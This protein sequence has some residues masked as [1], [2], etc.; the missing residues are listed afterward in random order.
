V[1]DWLERGLSVALTVCAVVI[2]TVLIHQ[3]FGS[4]APVEQQKESPAPPVRIDNWQE[5]LDAGLV[6]GDSNGGLHLVVFGDLECPYCRAFHMRIRALEQKYPG[7]ITLSY[8]H[9]PL[10]RHRF[11][12]PSARAAECARFQGRFGEFVD[13]VFAKQDSIGLKTWPS[14]AAEAGVPNRRRFMSCLQ[15]GR[16]QVRVEAGIA[17]G[18]RAGNVATPTVVVRGWRY[19]VPSA[20]SILILAMHDTLFP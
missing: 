6:A 16:S 10:Q 12:R 14:Y 3:E 19:S 13:V 4:R 7:E 18:T 2:A 20:D 15:D 1:P 11:A 8:I 5:L 9:S 17:L